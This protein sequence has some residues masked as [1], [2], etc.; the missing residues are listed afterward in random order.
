MANKGYLVLYTNPFGSDGRGNDFAYLTKWGDI[1]YHNFL[2]FVDIC[3]SKIPSMD[4]ANVFLTGGSYGGYR[5][6]WREVHTDKFKAIV[7]QRSIS[8]W[9][10][11]FANGDIG[12]NFAFGQTSHDIYSKE[13]FEELFN[14]SPIKYVKNAKTPI[15][16]L[17]S[18][19]DYRCP[20]EQGVQFFTALIHQ[21]VETQRVIFHGE[22]HD[23]SRGGKPKNRIT[24]LE[25]RLAFFDEHKTI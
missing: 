8:N 6:N 17:H 13:G 10:T 23:R 9:I 18:D 22:N 12:P 11:R 2:D 20:L 19:E 7:T 25:K 3:L 5:S 24:R 16:I 14:I 21:K 15:L 4:P 1:D